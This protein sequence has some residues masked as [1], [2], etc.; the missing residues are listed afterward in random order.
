VLQKLKIDYGL[1]LKQLER[2][3]K[4]LWML[5]MLLLTLSYPIHSRLLL[6]HLL[7]RLWPIC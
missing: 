7:L 6:R 3:L 1:P 2:Q 5:R 4:R